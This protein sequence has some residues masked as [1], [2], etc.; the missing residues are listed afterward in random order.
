MKGYKGFNKDL[1]CRDKQYK[2]NTI[3]E[4]TEAEIC[5]SGMHFCESPFDV[6]EHY[7]PC[8]DDGNLNKFAVVESLADVKTDDN[9][10]YCTTKL[11]VNAVLNFGDFVKA[12]INFILE[13]T[14]NNVKSNTGNYSA[15][16]NTGDRSAST[17]EGKDSIA[18]VTGYRGKAKG[19]IGC[20]IVCTERDDNYHIIDV[21]TAKVD[22]INVKE[23]TFYRL[24]NGIFVEVEET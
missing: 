12:G 10:K 1:I 13:K 4:E 23:D 2:E 16:T 7:P 18:I 17:V 3:F 9:K 6:W 11:K 15:S 24:E 14:K 19:K 8:N 22:G 21:K 5:E 20:W